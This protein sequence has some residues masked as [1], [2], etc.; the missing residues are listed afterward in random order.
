MEEIALPVSLEV[1]LPFCEVRRTVK[2]RFEVML[3]ERF[4]CRL[5]DVR[6][7]GFSEGRGGRRV[8]GRRNVEHG[9]GGAGCNSGRR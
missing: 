9:L 5:V 4:W 7:E 2:I 1:E 3:H 6:G 8:R